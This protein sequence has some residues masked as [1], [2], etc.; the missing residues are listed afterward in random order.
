MG[1]TADGYWTTQASAYSRPEDSQVICRLLALA[2][3]DAADAPA[4][5]GAASRSTGFLVDSLF[6]DRQK[7]VDRMRAV[8]DNNPSRSNRVRMLPTEP[9]ITIPAAADVDPMTALDE[10]FAQLVDGA[11]LLQVIKTGEGILTWIARKRGRDVSVFVAPGRPHVNRLTEAHKPWARAYFN[12]LRHGAAPPEFEATATVLF[13]RLMDEVR[14]NWGDLL[15][16]LVDDGI[17][18]LVLVGDDLVDIPLHAVPTGSG[19]ERLIDRVQVTYVPSL[20]AL[21]A[22][23]S[24]KRLDESKRKGVALRALFDSDLDSADATA[25]ALAATLETKPCKLSP[26]AASFWTDAAA[27]QVLHIDAR[28]THNARVPFDSLIGAGWLDL[29]IAELIAGLNLPHCEIVSNVA[30]E[31]AFPSMLRAPGLDLAAV[32][33]AAGA[34]SVLAS[35]WVVKDEL[36]S[37]LAQLYF[38]RWVSGYAPAEAF[39]RALRHLRAQQP[40]LE[41]FYWAGLRLVGA[42]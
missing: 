40:T 37:E 30:G 28:A 38:Q 34:R 39:Q 19:N 14:R 2:A 25:D 35:T 18:Q 36:A 31:S 41:D 27:A 29:S 16:E 42:P 7:W 1:D 3:D 33:L 10:I 17:T 22:C 8:V 32:F 5:L 24:R 11:A 6:Q 15:Q 12:F 20:G 4:F 26:G 9:P 23:I 13:S 21:H